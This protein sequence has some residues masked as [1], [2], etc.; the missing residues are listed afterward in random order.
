MSRIEARVEVDLPRPVSAWTMA[1]VA[2]AALWITGE[3]MPW[4]IFV[5]IVMLAVSFATRERPPAWRRNPFVLNACM[6]AITALTVQLAVMGRPATLSLAHFAALSQALQLVDARP[7]KSE[8]LLVALALF[9]VVLASNLT[10]SVLFPPMLVIFLVSVTWTLLIHTLRTEALEGGDV[11]GARRVVTRGLMRTTAVATLVSLVLAT[12]FFL[13]LPRMKSS[14]IRGGFG[15][16]LAMA[17]FSDQVELG[18]IGRIRQD[19]TVVLRVETLRGEPLAPIDAYWRGLAFDR[20][21]GQRWSISQ[22]DAG[23]GRELLNGHARFGMNV[24]GAP[25]A[26]ARVQ[27]I[28]REPVEAGVVFSA[29]PILRLE[30]P[31]QQI[32]RDTNGGVYDPAQTTER[33]RYTVWSGGDRRDLERLR[34]DVA[35][36]PPEI[37]PRAVLRRARYLDLPVF[38][39]RVLALGLEIT[40]GAATDADR[41]ESIERHLRS[42]GAYTDAPADMT[43]GGTHSPIEGFLLG[44]LAGHCEYFASGMVV[45]ARSQGLP[46][47][48]VNGFAGGRPNEVGGFT[49]LTSSD[50]HAWVE[51]HYRD[52]GWVRYDPTPPDA[53]LRAIGDATLAETFAALGSA[54]ELWWFQRVVDFDSSDQI[55]ALKSA[56]LF[57]RD[58][59][60]DQEHPGGS[61]TSVA[62]RSAP[63][64]RD[65]NADAESRPPIALAALVAVCGVAW[66][67]VRRRARTDRAVRD[68]PDDYARALRWLARR[69]YPRPPESTARDFVR[70]IRHELHPAVAEA[71]SPI[72]ERYLASRFGG[73]SETPLATVRDELTRLRSRLRAIRP[74]G[75]ERA[76]ALVGLG[77]QPHVIEDGRAS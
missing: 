31:L 72:T 17:G 69:G 6:L 28:V 60:P 57:L 13:M 63:S 10:D 38:D 21:D 22:F 1:A 45:L 77:D 11:E 75:L 54:I 7:R 42:T 2:S 62:D 66:L 73:Y 67:I 46:A 59:W 39:E 55:L 14:F 47:R 24:R 40:E 33:V 76:Q 71:F 5:Q 4:V 52:A 74:T 19:D 56:Y 43:E 16:P 29:G 20:F 9:Q 50:A 8:F 35:A 65:T 34:D 27:R 15:A 25:P 36:P 48:L 23:Y 12:G 53:R 37:G 3:L 49:E 32:E 61:D 68:L 30:G 41:A 58:L 44:E 18:T 70:Q 26:D 51:I 64:K